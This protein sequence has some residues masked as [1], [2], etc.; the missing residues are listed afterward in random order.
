MNLRQQIYTILRESEDIVSGEAIRKEL[1]VSRVAVWKHIQAMIK[2]GID[3]KSSTKGYQ[4]KSREDTLFPHEFGIRNDRI[5]FREE[6]SSTMDTAKELVR[7]G[8]EK[9]RI[10]IALKQNCGRGRLQREWISGT[11]GLYVSLVVNPAIPPQEANMVNLLAATEMASTLR[12]MFALDA[13]V[14]W[15]NDILIDGKKICGILS[16]MEIEGNQLDYL[17]LGIGLNVN[18]RAEQSVPTATS[19]SALLNRTVSRKDILTGFLDRFE[20]ALEHFDPVTVINEWRK[21]NCTIGKQVEIVTSNERQAGK[22]VD[23]DEQG[24]LVLQQ[25]NGQHITVLYGDC[26]H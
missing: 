3:I 18:N 8:Y 13:R 4:L 12:T 5:H 6:L 10:I 24:G 25:E 2:S 26:F 19:I 20:P 7:K 9:N 22:A 17:I 11:G 1:G 15:P 23:I 14:K 16:Q 21:I